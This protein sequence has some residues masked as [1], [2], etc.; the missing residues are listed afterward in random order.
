MVHPVVVDAFSDADLTLLKKPRYLLSKLRVVSGRNLHIGCK[1]GPK[2]MQAI[3]KGF[4]ERPACVS[5]SVDWPTHP[6]VR[7]LGPFK[8]TETM[9]MVKKWTG[10]IKEESFQPVR[11]IP[12]QGVDE[13]EEYAI[14]DTNEDGKRYPKK[15][16]GWGAPSRGYPLCMP[17]GNRIRRNC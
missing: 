8:L 7:G 6:A 14:V 10:E 13:G 16:T 12:R 2:W 15:T 9:Q 1:E 17:L 5:A 3:T 4:I 11:Y